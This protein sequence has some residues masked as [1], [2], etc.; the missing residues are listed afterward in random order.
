MTTKPKIELRGIQYAE[1]M[2]EE[3]NCYSA[4]LWVDGELWGTV[5]NHGT[6]GPDNFHG[7]NGRNWNDV[8]ALD[9]R[10]AATYEPLDCTDIGGTPLPM[11]LEL[12]C[13][14]LVGEWIQQKQLK[15]LLRTKA[16]FFK[17]APPADGES[18][19]LYEIPLKGRTIE[20]LKPL[21]E[22]RHPGAVILNSLPFPEAA[23]LF[24]RAG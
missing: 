4:H 1:R 16:V 19:P 5:S 24:N 10:I 3:T 6:G 9:E 17:S 14:A 23:E 7:A 12:V 2:S 22:Q 18:A 20:A 13:G 15:R 11:D 8:K 21:I